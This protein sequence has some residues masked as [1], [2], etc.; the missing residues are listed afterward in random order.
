MH[1]VKK[2]TLRN[3]SFSLNSLGNH[4]RF[5]YG[6]DIIWFMVQMHAL[7]DE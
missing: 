4:W 7:T 1:G 2:E 5:K 6:N 3:L